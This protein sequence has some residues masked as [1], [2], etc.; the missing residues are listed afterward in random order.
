MIVTLRG[1]LATL[2]LIFFFLVGRGECWP[3]GSVASCPPGDPPICPNNPVDDFDNLFN[4]PSDCHYFIYCLDGQPICKE[5]P[6]DLH[7]SPTL[8]FCDYP[9]QAGCSVTANGTT[10]P[11]VKS[12][13]ADGGPTAE[14]ET[15]SGEFPVGCKIDCPACSLTDE[16]LP[17]PF[18]CRWYFQCENFV[19]KPKECNDDWLFDSESR[20]CVCPDCNAKCGLRLSCEITTTEY[21]CPDLRG[22]E[23]PECP[24]LA[25]PTYFAHPFDCEFYFTCMK[26]VARCT[27]CPDGLHWNTKT[28]KCDVPERAGCSVNQEQ[29]HNVAILKREE[30][31]LGFAQ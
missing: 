10:P 4:H 15:I 27:R 22:A 19:P 17:H 24:Y 1:F 11:S 5:C 14:E 30:R 12:I 2:G 7:F 21:S 29:N 16:K 13:P 26:G 9:D 3:P 18:E 6:A 28:G 20:S 25:S 23:A 31:D 8:H